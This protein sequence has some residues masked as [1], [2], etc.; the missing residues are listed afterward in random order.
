MKQVL[1][2]TGSNPRKRILT[3]RDWK[4]RKDSNWMADEI[5]IR[6]IL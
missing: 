1:R 4:K 6:G 2:S 5:I 3:V